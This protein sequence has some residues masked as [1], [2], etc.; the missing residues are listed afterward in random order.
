MVPSDGA[1][2][3][4]AEWGVAAIAAIVAHAHGPSGSNLEYVCRLRD[5]LRLLGDWAR[6]EYIE[7][8]CEAA[9]AMIGRL[10]SP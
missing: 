7:S 4:D 6:D 2:G 3:S 10:A 8:V 5:A 9:E 1:R